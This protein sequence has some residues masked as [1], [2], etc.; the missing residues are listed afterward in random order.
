MTNPGMYNASDFGEKEVEMVRQFRLQLDDARE[1]F[2]QVVKPRLDRSYKLYIAYSGDRKKRIK[3][4][5]AN[6]FVPYIQAVIETL[7]PRILDARPEFSVLGRTEEDQAKS[8]KQQHLMDYLWERSNMDS[9]SEDFVR[10]A[11]IYGTSFLQVSWKKDVRKQK[12]LETKDITKK[13]KW[14]EEERTFYDDPFCEWVDNYSLWYDWHNT[15]RKSKQYWIKRLVLTEAEIRRRYPIA[16]RKRLEMALAAPGGDLND[17]AS[18]RQEVKSTHDEVFKGSDRYTTSSMSVD[19]FKNTNDQTMKMYEVFEWTRPFEDQY[20]VFVGGSYVPILPGGSMPIPFDFKE[21][22]FIETTYLKIPGEFEGYGI[23]IILESPQVMLNLMKNQRLDATTLSIHKMWVVNPLANINK[24]ELVTRPFGIIYSIDP[25]GVREI[26]FSDIKPSAYKEEELLKSDMRYSSGVD[27]FSMGVGGSAGSATEVRHLRESTLERVR[28]FVNH[29]GDAYADVMRYWIDMERQFFTK[30]MT[31][32]IIGDGGQEMYPLI[33]KDDLMGYFD[34]RAV[35]LPSIAGQQDVQKKQDMD[36]FQLLVQMPFI[37]PRKLTSKVL[38]NWNWSLDSVAKSEEEQ[39]QDP[40]Q[41]QLEQM[42]MA[43]GGG[44]PAGMPPG[45]PPT[46]QPAGAGAPSIQNPYIPNDVLR[47]SLSMLRNPADAV[48]A[49][50]QPS[51]FAQAASPINL[52]K[53]GGVPP[54]PRGVQPPGGTTNPRGMNRGGKVNTNI[55]TK[56]KTSTESNIM[57][58]ASSIQR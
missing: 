50:S 4:W 13:P 45:M 47:K 44:G 6:V 10:A 33:Q 20:A 37:D 53:G 14:K 9:V 51:P 35:V 25:N 42:G 3:S 57:N 39:S 55:S 31:I 30:D 43:Q 5:Q 12:F 34:Y 41:A 2:L 27:D 7:M 16:D 8:E 36:L 23:P 48:A 24:E 56:K 15:A 52:A 11:L 28:L 18:I 26:Q 21:A 46:G 29:L 38:K 40:M 17:Y 19:K 1:Y 22:P 54:T 32:R 58:R 49:A